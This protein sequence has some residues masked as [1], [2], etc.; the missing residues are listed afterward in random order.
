MMARAVLLV[1]DML[2]FLVIATLAGLT[3]L[4]VIQKRN[5]PQKS[6]PADMVVTEKAS[7]PSPPPVSAHNWMKR[8][9]ERANEVQ[10]Q[11]AQQHKDDRTK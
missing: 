5:E 9:L 7:S 4:F 6:R 8:S 10:Q 1:S 11:V 3:W 2:K